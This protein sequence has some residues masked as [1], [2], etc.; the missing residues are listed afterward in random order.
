M[1]ECLNNYEVHE[2]LGYTAGYVAVVTAT[3]TV[4]HD[5]STSILCLA[6]MST[7]PIGQTRNTA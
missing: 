6:F 7:I 1:S 3:G 5:S 4:F 2:P